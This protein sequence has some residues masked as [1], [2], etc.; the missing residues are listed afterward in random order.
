MST[1][2]INDAMGIP[3]MESPAA[4][5]ILITETPEVESATCD[6]CGLTEECTPEYIETIRERYDGKW[7]CGLCGEA[8]K[9]EIVRNKRLI[10]TEEAL[11]SHVSF[12][13]SPIPSGSPADPTVRLIAAVRQIFRRSLDSP[14]AVRSM[15]CSPTT[16]ISDSTMLSRSESCI[17]DIALFD[18][19]KKMTNDQTS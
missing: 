18:D 7:I 5:T 13:R 12:C 11:A 16:T 2:V 6:C 8:V 3:V 14:A 10:S 4:S 17:S 1:Y 19:S 15:P 9:D